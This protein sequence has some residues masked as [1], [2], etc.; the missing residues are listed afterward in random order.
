MSAK[1][2]VKLLGAAI[3]VMILV[4][5]V[6]GFRTFTGGNLT[7]ARNIAAQLQ[8]DAIANPNPVAGPATTAGQLGTTSTRP[9]SPAA[10]ASPAPRATKS[11]STA[12]TP[13]PTTTSPAAVPTATIPPARLASV[14]PR[15]Q[16]T[17]A[18]ISQAISAVNSVIP[19]YTPT[20]SDIAFA[21][22]QVCTAFDQGQ[23]L[24]QVEAKA[25]DMVGAGS[26]ASYIP[27][28]VPDIAIRTVVAL[29]C[30]GYSAKLK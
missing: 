5:V 15:R 28:S 4:A 20:P 2:T 27:S 25:L 11:G 6:I 19:F 13:K 17:A 18:E 7:K 26:F 22:N 23:T 24:S 3:V 16:P 14:V 1:K 10:P 30:P 29:Y 9:A 12:T 21:G 8:A